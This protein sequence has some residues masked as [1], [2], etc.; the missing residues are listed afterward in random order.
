MA[1]IL[2]YRGKGEKLMAGITEYI[3]IVDADK[4]TVGDK[5]ANQCPGFTL[6]DTIV[7][8]EDVSELPCEEMLIPKRL[9]LPSLPMPVHPSLAKYEKDIRLYEAMLGPPLGMLILAISILSDVQHMIS[10][11]PNVP[12]VE[13]INDAKALILRMANFMLRP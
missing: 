10:D 4:V 6:H 7:L 12:E 13:L 8:D 3:I 1:H 11:K 9:M 2:Y 5:T